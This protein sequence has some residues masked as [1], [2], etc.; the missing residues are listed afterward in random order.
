MLYWVKTRLQNWLTSR[1]FC[2]INLNDVFSVD[3]RILKVGGEQLSRQEIEQLKIEISFLERSFLW[4]LMQEKI[5][6]NAMETAWKK[7]TSFDDIKTAKTMLVNLDIQNSILEI[8]KN[9]KLN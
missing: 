8:I 4:K 7:S 9:Y 3:G 6:S 2:S 1:L 5:R